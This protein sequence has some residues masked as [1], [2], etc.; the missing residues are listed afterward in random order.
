MNP[1][2]RDFL[3]PKWIQ[4]SIKVIT[5]LQGAWTRFHNYCYHITTRCMEHPPLHLHYRLLAKFKNCPNPFYMT[6]FHPFCHGNWRGSQN[7]MWRKPRQYRPLLREGTRYHGHPARMRSRIGARRIFILKIATERKETGHMK[8]LTWGLNLLIILMYLKF[9]Q[10]FC[11]NRLV[12]AN[13]DGSSRP[14]IVRRLARNQT[15]DFKSR[16]V[17]STYGFQMNCWFGDLKWWDLWPI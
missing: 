3:N 16:I 6:C 2:I 10:G 9:R 17:R 12:W 11:K 13:P 8:M 5:A 7:K 14:R 15:Q 4:N 1:F